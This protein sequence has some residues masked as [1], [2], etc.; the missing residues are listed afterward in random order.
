M[1]RILW[2]LEPIVA[3]R[4]GGC[5]GE[6]PNPRNTS[7]SL[8][9]PGRCRNTTQ[10]QVAAY[11]RVPESTIRSWFYGMSYGKKPHTRRFHPIL[12]PAGKELLAFYDA[13]SAHVLSALKAQ[14]VPIN[15]I[16]AIVQE[17]RE[18]LPGNKYP[19]LGRNF[20]LFGKNVIIK[21]VGRRINLSLGPQLG[22]RHII[23]KF[24]RRLELDENKMPVRF[25]PIVDHK[26]RT[27]AFIVIDPNLSGGRP[28]IK[29]TGITAKSLQRGRQAASPQLDFRKITA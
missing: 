13:A 17:L 4:I 6:C 19:L 7:I 22:F 24:L 29:G 25:S 14:G 2:R 11:L 8:M 21:E 16:R 15:D 27:R 18:H 3:C 10:G 28:V 9:T 26:K 23:D 1:S 20:Y 5:H 12:S